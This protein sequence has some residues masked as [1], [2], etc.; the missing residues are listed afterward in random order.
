MNEYPESY[1]ELESIF[2]DE[3]KCLDYLIASRWPDG[4]RC[5][6]CRNDKYRKTGR[7]LICSSCRKNVHIMAD[8]IF[9]DSRLP[10]M[11]WY[12]VMWRIVSQKE[13]VKILDLRRLFD[14]TPITSLHILQK[15]R[16]AMVRP[17]R[18]RLTGTVEVDV[19]GVNGVARQK[20]R[21][22]AE[23]KELVIVAAEI[24]DHQSE[25]SSELDWFSTLGTNPLDSFDYSRTDLNNELISR[26]GMK[27]IRSV[28]SEE[29]ISFIKETIE[30]GSTVVTDDRAEY[31]D[32]KLTE[33]GYIHLIK[34]KNPINN[35]EGFESINELVLLLE[36]WMPERYKGAIS[37]DRFLYY[38]DEFI[39]RY[40]H[41][42]FNNP[43]V[44]FKIIL[45][46][47]AQIEPF[48]WKE[49]SNLKIK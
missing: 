31:S 45:D 46:N 3:E 19:T 16:R 8:T 44:L 41:R 40:N 37:L 11:V 29:L 42:N 47:A 9:Q 17:G 48:T 23:N 4:C 28:S 15:L 32:L 30:P 22:G 2:S 36:N 20:S 27:V 49:V 35:D 34:A 13:S 38:M 1:V 43:G 39:F 6:E 25:D 12:R 24:N 7:R 21:K 33:N 26:A 10:L 5:P 18:E 14:L